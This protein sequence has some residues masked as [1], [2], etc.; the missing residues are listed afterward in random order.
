MSTPA[1][2][3]SLR[4]QQA[5]QKPVLVKH[6]A[7]GEEFDGLLFVDTKPYG[8]EFY[9]GPKCVMLVPS[10]DLSKAWRVFHFNVEVL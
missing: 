9:V 8:V 1:T 3:L 7:T 5:T 6:R 10:Y 2:K 4:A